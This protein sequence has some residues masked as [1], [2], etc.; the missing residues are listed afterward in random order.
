MSSLFYCNWISSL[1]CWE[2]LKMILFHFPLRCYV[3]LHEYLFL[4]SCMTIS[5]SYIYFHI[6][7]FASI[8]PLNTWLW[9][10][11]VLRYSGK[12]TESD[13]YNNITHHFWNWTAVSM[14]ECSWTWEVLAWTQ[15]QTSSVCFQ[16]MTTRGQHNSSVT[17]VFFLSSK[18]WE[19]FK[20]HSDWRVRQHTKSISS[21]Q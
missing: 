4:I 2:G 10:T 16:F 3:L 21:I 11:E 17:T 7:V 6:F 20:H 18:L 15:S 1:V 19:Q 12:D 8:Y 9:H 13:C 14:Y 5:V